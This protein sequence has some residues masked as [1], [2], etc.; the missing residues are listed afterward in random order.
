ML[1]S[2]LAARATRACADPRPQ[3]WS[4]W[5]H[6]TILNSLPAK[7][8]RLRLTWTTYFGSYPI[9]SPD[10]AVPT[11][12]P[13]ASSTCASRVLAPCCRS[14]TASSAVLKIS[15]QEDWLT[16]AF[17]C[18]EMRRHAMAISST[19]LAFFRQRLRLSKGTSGGAFRYSFIVPRAR[20]EPGYSWLATSCNA[21]A[22]RFGKPW[23]GYAPSGR[24]HLPR[25]AG[26]T[27]LSR[28]FPR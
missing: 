4:N 12:N 24:S 23:R 10:A 16:R 19:V 7:M 20:T 1:A 18:R 27:L 9:C 28:F 5:R 11:S 6:A 26:T 14:T 25:K 17:R 8:P 13:G 22:A 2:H 15:R 3:R 21:K